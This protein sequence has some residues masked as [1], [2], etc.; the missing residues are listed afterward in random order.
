MNYSDREKSISYENPPSESNFQIP[1][2][3]ELPL[4]PF[5]APQQDQDPEQPPRDSRGPIIIDL[6]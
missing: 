5:Q 4:P 3:I 2:Y 1:L 6:V